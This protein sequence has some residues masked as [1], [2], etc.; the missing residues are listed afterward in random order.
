MFIL[1]DL[2]STLVTIEWMDIL[3][4]RKGKGE[5]IKRITEETMN[6]SVSFDSV[7][8]QK[9][10]ILSPTVEELYDLGKYYL[11]YIIAGMPDLLEKLQREWHTLGIITYNYDIP[12]KIVAE[13]LQIPLD[14]VFGNTV[15]NQTGIVSID[16][17]SLLLSEDGKVEIIRK[18][19]QEFPDACFIFVGDSVGDMKTKVVAD[20]FIGCGI[21]C[22]REKVEKWAENFVCTIQQLE[23]ILCNL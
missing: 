8:K 18:L 5:E 13:Y 3:A 23:T 14:Y 16:P 15:L 7:F 2:D 4:K 17:H 11:H 20:M 1:F 9:L 21:V 10:E 12:A 19:R 6:G 22:R